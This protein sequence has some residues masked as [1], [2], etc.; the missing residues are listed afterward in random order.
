MYALKF[1]PEGHGTAG[2]DEV[3]F[4]PTLSVNLASSTVDWEFEFRIK[5]DALPSGS[6]TYYFIGSSSTASEGIYIRLS[7]G[8]YTLAFAVS[9]TLRFQSSP[10]MILA[11]GE[12]HTWI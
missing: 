3:V 9:S 6:G 1:N 12:F 8:V 11:D 5:L 4:S 7:A 10:D 2:N